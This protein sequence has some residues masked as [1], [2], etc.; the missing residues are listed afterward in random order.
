[1]ERC[2]LCGEGLA[3]RF[4]FCPACG[5]PRRQKLTEFFPADPQL[6]GDSAGLRVSRYLTGER[7]TRISIWDDD[8]A[9]AVLSLDEQ[10]AA[11]LGRFLL[12]GETARPP[13]E[14]TTGRLRRVFQRD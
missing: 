8:A 9:R 14:Q 7:H 5:A 4:L 6:Q 3:R 13:S 10:S 12:L 11:R 1:M 2:G